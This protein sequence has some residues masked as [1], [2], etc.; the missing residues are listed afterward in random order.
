[1]W[2]A[3][4]RPD[5]YPDEI[6]Y[7][8]GTSQDEAARRVAA[9]QADLVQ[10]VGDP[11]AARQLAAQHPTQVHAESQQATIFAFLNTRTPPFDDVRVRRA[12]N[13]AI[14][15]QRLADLLGTGLA[16]PTCQIIPPTTTGYR[17]Y[18][19][20]TVDPDVAGLWR[21]PDLASARSLVDASGTKGQAV[22]LWTGPDFRSEAD[23]VAGVIDQLGYRT[24]VHE[25]ADT[26][27]LLRRSRP[28]ADGPGGDVRLV[29]Q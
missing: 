5:G 22:A 20:Y 23:Y 25:V 15:R 26:E 2:A 8:L 9:G 17:P 19:P 6:D 18:C 12:L 28:D 10:L 29:R 3:A 7:L 11:P 14:D 24:N 1:M 4:A 16:R 27:Q 21:G 13:F